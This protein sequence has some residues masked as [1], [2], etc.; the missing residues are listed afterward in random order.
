MCKKLDEGMFN[1]YRW[2]HP[3]ILGFD[4]ERLKI[5]SRSR[6]IFSLSDREKNYLMF[7]YKTTKLHTEKKGGKLILVLMW[8]ILHL[9]KILTVSKYVFF[10]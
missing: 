10:N 8:Y 3:N 4:N 5:I 7:Y 2:M 1:L 6:K 9:K